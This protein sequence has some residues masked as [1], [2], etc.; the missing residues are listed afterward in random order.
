MSDFTSPKQWLITAPIV[1]RLK[2]N[3]NMFVGYAS[4]KKRWA[5]K[6]D[7]EDELR[8]AFKKV[9]KVY[10]HKANCKEEIG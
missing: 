5:K 2:L 3:K 10:V 1:W 8:A 6:S 9:R 4:G 7:I